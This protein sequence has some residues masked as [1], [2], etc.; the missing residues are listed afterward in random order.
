MSE[1]K[2]MLAHPYSPRRITSWDKI[3]VEPK[4]D[5]VRVAAQIS[6]GKGGQNP[7]V[8]L[9]S[10]NGR[11]LTM[12]KHLHMQLLDVA[13]ALYVESGHYYKGVMLDGEMMCASFADVAG[14][15]HTKDWQCEDAVY[16]VFACVPI[17]VQDKDITAQL[18][19]KQE[20][21]RAFKKARPEKV[22][23][24]GYTLANNAA[25]IDS[26]YKRFK[27][28]GFEGAIVKDLHQPWVAKR[29][30]AWMKL[31]D[32]K[33]VD[34][35]VIATIAGTGKYKGMIGALVVDYKGKQVRVSGMTDDQR[36]EWSRD[37]KKILRKVVE[38]SY[39][40]ETEAGS[41]RHPRFKRVREDKT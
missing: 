39:Q 41:L 14:A 26:L 21:Q 5:G 19:R 32:E 38:V 4:L 25:Q 24:V 6:F 16:H 27:R 15:I 40:L 23:Y 9:T 1:L 2:L 37:P 31:K 35:K 34:V 36:K 18:F 29:S 30:Y 10:R 22:I 3:G 28:A 33:S 11:E 17:P 12:F 7:K 20:L 13:N 8:V